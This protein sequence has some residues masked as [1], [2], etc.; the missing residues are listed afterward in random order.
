MV[1][2]DSH[3]EQ[4]RRILR[5]LMEIVMFHKLSLITVGGNVGPDI[6]NGDRDSAGSRHGKWD[7]H[8]CED[9]REEE[10]RLGKRQ[11]IEELKEA[12]SSNSNSNLVH[13]CTHGDQLWNK[14]L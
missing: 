3:G 6:H 14:L 1:S 12:S 11:Q 7:S 4:S 8:I 10:G 5:S 13:T 9:K 2:P